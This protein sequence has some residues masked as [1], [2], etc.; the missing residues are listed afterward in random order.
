MLFVLATERELKFDVCLSMG[1]I[2]CLVYQGL[3]ITLGC[4]SLEVG[5]CVTLVNA[6]VIIIDEL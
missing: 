2:M 6:D 3:A 1:I 5:Y 4:D